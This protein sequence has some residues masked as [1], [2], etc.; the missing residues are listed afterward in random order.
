MYLSPVLCMDYIDKENTTYICIGILYLLVI[1]KAIN[2]E[3]LFQDCMFKC[4][5]Y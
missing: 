5:L 1:Y 3:N 4:L 2:M